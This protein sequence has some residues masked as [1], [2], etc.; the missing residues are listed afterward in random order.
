MLTDSKAIVTYS[1]LGNSGKGTAS[2]LSI[3][4]TAI[5]VGT[6]VVFEAGQVEYTSVAMLTDSKAIV[7]YKDVGNSDYGTACILSISGDAITAKTPAVFDS[8][9][10]EYI[11]V[12]ALS[13]SKAIVAYSSDSSAYYGTACVLSISGTT[14]EAGNAATFWAAGAQY[15]SATMLTD[16][17]A[18]V[19]YKDEG[20]A[21]GTARI[22]SI[23]GST[24]SVGP[25]L[26]FSSSESTYISVAKLNEYKAI[27]CYSDGG[28]SN[29]G[30][31]CNL[32]ISGTAIAAESSIVFESAASYDT[33]V[34]MLTDSKAVVAYTGGISAYGTACIIN[35]QSVDGISISESTNTTASVVFSGVAQGL[36]GLVTGS[37]YYVQTD[38]TIDVSPSL[39]IIGKA[40][41][42][43][44]LLLKIN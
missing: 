11:S 34:A 41:S 17:K 5:T 25:S 35:G 29:Y 19:C 28:N 20:F 10:S 27:V 36:S 30:T 40:I 23:S 8:S 9:Y 15:I 12:S 33:A 44:D 13:D 39:L 18:I 16:S 24:I 26:A 22:L 2:I 14:I 31:F 1:D 7:C 21:Y 37:T 42:T 3:S 38:G 6:P 4:G 32:T 43:T